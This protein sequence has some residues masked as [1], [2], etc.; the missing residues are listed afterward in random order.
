[1]SL[2][3]VKHQTP[4]ISDFEIS[5][6]KEKADVI[7]EQWKLL[8]EDVLKQ[9]KERNIINILKSDKCMNKSLTSKNR[10][11]QSENCYG[12]SVVKNFMDEFYINENKEICV[13]TGENR[14]SVIKIFS[15][16]N[17][18]TTMKYKNEN[19]NTSNPFL[20]YV[21]ISCIL[22]KVLKNKNYPSYIPY[23]WSFICN[24]TFNIL[25][26]IK[27]MKTLKEIS[28]NPSLSKSS[29]LAKTTVHNILN[30][31]IMRD[32]F[33]QLILLCYFYSKYKFSHGEPSINY[34]NFSP[35]KA[36][37]TFQGIKVNSQITL[38]ISPS[39][40]SSVCYD[41]IRYGL[42]KT[43]EIFNE[44]PI[45]SKDIG[46]DNL[47]WSGDYEKHRIEYYK[48]GNQSEKFRRSLTN[49]YYFYPSFDCI[50]FLSSLVSDKS[51]YEAFRDSKYLSIW[52]NL[53]KPEEYDSLMKKLIASK[54]DFDSIF[55]IVKNYHM[56]KNT[57]QY[58]MGCLVSLHN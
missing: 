58:C 44:L 37:F 34:L 21:V 41:D 2:P 25:I 13:Q 57:L 55:N 1:M 27:H 39:T 9:V 20:N 5:S 43:T 48:I 46:L 42:R 6:D 53:W 45:E 7:F 17:T 56:R 12:C 18:D 16:N 15:Y 3:I 22:E 26:N 8:R 52:K 50:M 54:S 19:C 36:N 51:F 33:M 14:N 35:Y 11:L 28:L 24:Q 10:L 47:Y 23:L 31:K 4:H 49:G 30:E 29:P 40:K 32:I 38:N